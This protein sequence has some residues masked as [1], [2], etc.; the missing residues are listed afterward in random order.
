MHGMSDTLSV[1][2]LYDFGPTGI[3]EVTI[4]KYAFHISGPNPANA[5]TTFSYA[6]GKQKNAR[7]LISNLLGSKVAEVSLNAKSGTHT[8]ALNDYKSGIYI[9]SL[10]VEGS[11]VNSKKLI[12][13]HR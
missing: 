4:S 9:C 8:L 3:P 6:L 1:T 11:I 2:Y 13:S 7:I 5:I 10:I 12:V